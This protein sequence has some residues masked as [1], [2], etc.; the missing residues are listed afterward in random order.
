MVGVGANQAVGA[1]GGAGAGGVAVAERAARVT[2]PLDLTGARDALL[3]LAP[4]VP[5]AA[6]IVAYA[7][8]FS[9]L[10]VAVHDGY[11]TPAFDMSIPDQGIW[12]LSRFHAPFVTVMGRNL[13]ADH[14]SFI[15]VLAV[16]LFWI[17]PHTQALLVL[18]SCLLASAAIPIYLLGRRLLGRTAVGTGLSTA[19]AAVYLL[20]PAL[21]NGNLEQF[22]VEAFLVPSLAWAIYAAVEWK[23]VVLGAAVAACLLCKED[24]ALLIIPLGVWILFKRNRK[25]GAAIVGIAAAWMAFAFEVI[26]PTIL[27]SGSVHTNRVPFGGYWGFVKAIFTKPGKVWDYVTSGGRLFY[28]WQMGASLGWAFVI[29]PS[30]AAIGIL[31]FLE[32]ELAD[33]VYQHQIQYHY[34]MPLV[35]VLAIGTVW[36]VSRLRSAQLRVALTGVATSSALVGCIL[37]GL[38]PF[39]LNTYPHLSTSSPAVRD[40][41]SVIKALPAN[42]VVSAWYPY[43]AHV[44]H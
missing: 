12:L 34:S 42:A 10:S 23:P 15:L 43:V 3:R 33:F 39:S 26:T 27:G 11:G 4:H 25:W 8:R 6:L 24:T 19:L 32:N 21:Q 38:A 22:H 7:V 40:A 20:N 17:Y 1:G 18:Q 41:N 30:V 13:F 37:W 36:A 14:T 16:P 5:V 2:R 29:G 9:L 44:D 35:P 31:A 28:A